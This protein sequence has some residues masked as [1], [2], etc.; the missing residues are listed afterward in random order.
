[1]PTPRSRPPGTAHGPTPHRAV[2]EHR[3]VFPSSVQLPLWFVSAWALVTLPLLVVS[4]LA[5][6]ARVRAGRGPLA[7][8]SDT[9]EEIAHAQVLSHEIRTP[10]A[11]VRGA[12]ELLSEETPGPLTP[13]QRYFV[14]TVVQ[15]TGQAISMAE[16]FLLDA[17]L[18]HGTTALEVVPTDL[19]VLVRDVVRELRRVSDLSIH[20]DDRGEPLVAR[21]DPGLIRQV[22][23]NLVNNALRHSGSTV[24]TVRIAGGDEGA[25]ISVS[26]DGS[27]MDPSRRQD[28]FTP[29]S[30]DAPGRSGTGLGM[31]ITRGIVEAHGGRI[32]V[33][34]MARH[35]TTVFAVIPLVPR[36][37]AL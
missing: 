21:V 29:F 20:L 7:H 18:R 11:L 36:G 22:I 10:L 32:V 3:D 17:R 27:G 26:D 8:G 6:V 12:A 35:G 33:D 19:R 2:W 28:L 37:R 24:V 15:N 23:W 9:A 5:C 13:T 14:D 25:I 1:M 16:D 4:A 30:S 31:S 34:T